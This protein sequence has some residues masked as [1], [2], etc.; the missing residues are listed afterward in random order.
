M[1]G[2]KGYLVTS[3]IS[4]GTA[5]LHLW[6]VDFTDFQWKDTVASILFFTASAIYFYQYLKKR[7]EEVASNPIKE[8]TKD[9]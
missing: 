3:I 2:S 6:L 4:L 5:L 8:G 7:K 9:K 1:N